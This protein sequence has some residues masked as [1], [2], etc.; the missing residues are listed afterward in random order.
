MTRRIR[1]HGKQRTT[2]NE[3]RLTQ[4][5][6]LIAAELHEACSENGTGGVA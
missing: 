1:I 3:E 4:A 5:L 6:L 2:I